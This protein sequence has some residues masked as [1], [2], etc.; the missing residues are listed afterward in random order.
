MLDNPFTPSDIASAPDEFFGRVNELSEAKGALSKGSVSIQGQIGIGK[1]SLLARIRLE[2]EGFQSDHTATSVIAV[3]HKDIRSADD[4]ARAVLE[5]MIEVDEAHKKVT[6]K[7][8]TLFAMASGE[9]YRNFVSGRHTAA[10]LRLIERE[11]LKQILADRELLIIAIDEADKCPAAIA[12]LFRQ[13]ATTAQHRGIKGVRF[14][15]A[16]VSP[17]YKQMLLEDPGIARFTYKTITLAPMDREEATQLIETKLGL[18]VADAKLKQMPLNID[19]NIIQQIVALS[20]GH[21]HLLQLLGSYLID[22]ENDDPDG[23]LDAQDLTTALRRICYEDRAQVYDSTLHKLDVEGML[24]AFRK[25][26]LAAP[27]KF[28]TCIP[29]RDALKITAPEVLQWM[30]ENNIFTVD[31]DGAYILLDEFLRVRLLMDGVEEED[32]KSQIEERLLAGSWTLPEET[33]L[34]SKGYQVYDDNRRY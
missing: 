26:V 28:P 11:Y 22:N 15:L 21:P 5:D 4:L 32:R 1:S 2:M 10:L 31:S 29:K 8:G 17:F 7:L 20:G 3:G 18:V 6:L 34:L 9:I 19:P 14:L 23:L 24:T 16:G 25:L 33:D 27:T 13:I 30:F 12:Q